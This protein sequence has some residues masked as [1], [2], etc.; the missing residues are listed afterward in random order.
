[1]EK[2][3]YTIDEVSALTKLPQSLIRHYVRVL[4]VTVARAHYPDINPRKVKGELRFTRKDVD[5]ILRFID[6]RK[7]ESWET[8]QLRRIN[9]ILAK[10]ASSPRK[11]AKGR[12]LRIIQGEK[13]DPRDTK[14]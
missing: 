3:Y 4:E 12:H 7:N 11:A 5:E 2:I 6:K 13:K 9:E 8:W 14:P 1:L 10:R